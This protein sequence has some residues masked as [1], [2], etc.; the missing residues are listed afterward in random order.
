MAEEMTA[1][2]VGGGGTD[3]V[4]A[5]PAARPR[6]SSRQRASRRA[7]LRRA[8]WSCRVSAG[9]GATAGGASIRRATSSCGDVLVALVADGV[10][11]RDGA[12][13]SGAASATADGAACSGAASAM[14]D[15]AAPVDD[16]ALDGAASGGAASGGEGDGG[17]DG[18]SDGGDG[19]AGATR[20]S[21]GRA[22]ARRSARARARSTS[23][24]TCA[25]PCARYFS[26]GGAGGATS[27]RCR[28]SRA[29]AIFLW[30]S[31]CAF[32]RQRFGLHPLHD[33]P[34]RRVSKSTS[35][36]HRLHVVVSDIVASI[37]SRTRW[38]AAPLP[39]LPVSL[40]RCRWL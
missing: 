6:L 14:A 19:S 15:G 3:G 13:C 22:A 12:A 36:P 32:G 1:G 2:T 35:A 17:G 33:C 24:I 28:D 16:A 21:C 27:R 30:P 8:S 5:A 4:A 29:A 37:E 26:Y 20:R 18:G 11:H 7:S 25:R 10:A 23:A 34:R 40:A 39:L 9:G 38:L 31:T